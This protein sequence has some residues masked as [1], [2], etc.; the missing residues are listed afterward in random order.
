[1]GAEQAVEHSEEIFIKL[2]AVEKLF[3]VI[4]YIPESCIVAS[5][6]SMCNCTSESRWSSCVSSLRNVEFTE[7]QPD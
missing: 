2:N 4:H 3:S 7:L 6:E 5:S 1:M